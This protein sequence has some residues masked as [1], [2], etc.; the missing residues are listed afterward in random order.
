MDLGHRR[1][2]R[3]HP[4]DRRLRT[5][6]GRAVQPSARGVRELHP[7]GRLHHK[8]GT[9]QVGFERFTAGGIWNVQNIISKYYEENI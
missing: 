1:P 5:S 6:G 8:S 3:V 2:V 4:V 9:A 7:P